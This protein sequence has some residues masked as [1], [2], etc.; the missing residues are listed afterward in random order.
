MDRRATGV[1]IL[2]LVLFTA[3][4]VPSLQPKAVAGRASMGAV[5]PPPHIGQ[6]LLQNPPDPAVLVSAQQS[7][8]LGSCAGAHYGEVARI[9]QSPTAS[10]DSTAPAAV[11]PCADLSGYL[12]WKP[13]VTSATDVRWQPISLSVVKMVPV[14]L[15]AAFGQHWVACVVTPQITGTSYSGSI[16]N[17]M[18]TGLLPTA[19]ASCHVSIE[20]DQA[21]VIDCREPHR[22]EMFA[23]AMLSNGFRDQRTLDRDCRKIVRA[24]TGRADPSAAGALSISSTPFHLDSAG[25]AGPGYPDALTNPDAEGVCAVRVLGSRLLAGSLFGIAEKALP[26]A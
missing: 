5:P 21:G 22:Y 1:L 10:P 16:R 3:A 13:P 20:V 6:C 4:V 14:A 25:N 12:G 15:Q 24:A 2:A 18:S 23:Y 17:A 19:F 11:D 7:Y 8:R 9:T 26:W